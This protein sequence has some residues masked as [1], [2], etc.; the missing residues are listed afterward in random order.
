MHGQKNI[1]FH[2]LSR[3]LPGEKPTK[4]RPKADQK[5]TNPTGNEFQTLHLLS[6][7]LHV[8]KISSYVTERDTPEE[9]GK[10]L[11]TEFMSYSHM[12]V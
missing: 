11:R 5:P 12:H 3:R 8:H 10:F 4:S 7:Y 6:H 2:L 1:K 9:N